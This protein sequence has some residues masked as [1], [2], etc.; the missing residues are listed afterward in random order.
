VFGGMRRT[1]VR[2]WC[3]R[4]FERRHVEYSDGL[5]EYVG[6][7]EKGGE[8]PRCAVARMAEECRNTMRSS[9]R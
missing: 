6:G 5:C 2:F 8:T 3:A 4:A 9:K 7:G 1:I